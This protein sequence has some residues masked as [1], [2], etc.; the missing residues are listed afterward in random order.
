[1]L[2]ELGVPVLELAIDLAELE[3]RCLSEVWHLDRAEKGVA[4]GL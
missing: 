1:V 4:A 2:V 3:A